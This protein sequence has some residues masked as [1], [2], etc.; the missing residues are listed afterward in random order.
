M[1]AQALMPMAVFC[2]GNLFGTETFSQGRAINM[3]VVTIGV[4]IAAF[5][6]LNFVLIGFVLQLVSIV[7][8][9]ARLTMVQVR[10][11]PQPSPP[12]HIQPRCH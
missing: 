5:G 3:V 2:V 9:A 8:E 7:V 4:M 10:P 11:S 6:E 1:V 12:R